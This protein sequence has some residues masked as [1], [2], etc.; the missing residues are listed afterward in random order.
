MLDRVSFM[1]PLLGRYVPWKSDCLVQAI[2]AQ[3]WLAA[4]DMPSEIQIGADLSDANL[5]EAHA[6]LIHEG[7]II[8]G[9]DISRFKVLI[10]SD[11]TDTLGDKAGPR[12][13]G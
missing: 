4:N 9:G 1:I 2:A 10:A 7:S 13:M 6:W 12:G 8:V 11:R 5:F 3:N